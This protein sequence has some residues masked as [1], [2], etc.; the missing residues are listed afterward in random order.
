MVVVERPT[1]RRVLL[2]LLTVLGLYALLLP[3]WWGSKTTY[4]RA[5]ANVA[6]VTFPLIGVDGGVTA[7]PGRWTTLAYNL[8][9]PTTGAFGQCRQRFLDFADLPLA[10]ALALGLA[11]LGFKRRLLVAGLSAL[12]VFLCHVVLIDYTAVRL[13][14][15]LNNPANTPESLDQLLH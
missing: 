10:L 13:A 12:A 15:I 7:Q 3:A 11:V 8:S 9:Y 6:S 1:T 14:G 5:A 2:S 4:A